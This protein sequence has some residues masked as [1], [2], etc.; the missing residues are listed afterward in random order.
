M[1][2]IFGFNPTIPPQLC[3]KLELAISMNNGNANGARELHWIA[4]WVHKSIAFHFW[5]SRFYHMA[6]ISLWK[7]RFYF[8]LRCFFLSS[9]SLKLLF[10]C[11]CCCCCLLVVTA[12]VLILSPWRM[13]FHSPSESLLSTLFVFGHHHQHHMVVSWNVCFRIH[14]DTHGEHKHA[15]IQSHSQSHSHISTRS[16]LHCA[17]ERYWLRQK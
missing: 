5:G 6:A 16:H 9:S 3:T 14:K 10:W 15:R 17:S 1:P 2:C 8:V 4:C 7:S 13:I 11:C 12:V